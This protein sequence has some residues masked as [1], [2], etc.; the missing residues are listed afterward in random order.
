MLVLTEHNPSS[1]EQSSCLITLESSPLPSLFKR[2][3][4]AVSS[5]STDFSAPNSSDLLFFV[6]YEASSKD[7]VGLPPGLDEFV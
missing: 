2:S 4:A 6:Q 5:S 7:E 1:F 3:I